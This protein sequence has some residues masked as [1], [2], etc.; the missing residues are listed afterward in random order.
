MELDIRQIQEI[1]PHRYPFLLID[2]VTDM[3]QGKWAEAVKCVTVNEPFFQGHFPGRPIM[4]GGL[5]MEALAQTGAVAILSEAENRG[6]LV[7]FGGIKNCRFKRQVVPGD[8][9]TLYCEL[10]ERRG[11]IGYGKAVA[12]VDGEIAA[13][14][15]LSFVI[16]Q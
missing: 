3:E 11:P 15:E 6:K 4:P 13:Q 2:R 16:T 12:K 9:L 1:L 10:T 5:I 7:V 14:G 8:V